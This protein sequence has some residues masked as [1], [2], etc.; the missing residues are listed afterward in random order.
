LRPY[1]R[2]KRNSVKLGVVFLGI[3][4]LTFALVGCDDLPAE[5]DQPGDMAPPGEAQP[6][7]PGP[8]E[9][10][11][12]PGPGAAEPMEPGPGEEPGDMAALPGEAMEIPPIDEATI[13]NLTAAA[14]AFTASQIN[15]VDYANF[16]DWAAA[17]V[18]VSG[19]E[20]QL[21]I[22]QYSGS[23]WALYDMGSYVEPGDLPPGIPTEVRNWAFP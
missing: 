17:R 9:Q 20:S 6:M 23:A 1:R 11:M 19:Q 14:S 22:F 4:A 10:P 7:E 5:P 13:K 15:V 2:S 12:E 3:I 16:G 21:A 18:G 8:G